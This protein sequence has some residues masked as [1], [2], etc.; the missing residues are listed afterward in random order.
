MLFLFSFHIGNEIVH[1]DNFLEKNV[2]IKFQF[3]E[4]EK[5]KTIIEQVGFDIIDIVERQTYKSEHQ[6]KELIF[7]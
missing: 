2:N 5:I 1:L 7:G 3:F 4:A 6:Q